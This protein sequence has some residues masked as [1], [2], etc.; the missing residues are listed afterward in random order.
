MNKI[1]YLFFGQIFEN[2]VNNQSND[3]FFRSEFFYYLFIVPTIKM[4][5]KVKVAAPSSHTQKSLK[6]KTNISLRIF[7]HPNTQN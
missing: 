4:H 1:I 7:P 3:L 5:S 6:Q 2:W